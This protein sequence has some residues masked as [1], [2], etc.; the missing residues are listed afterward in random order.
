[1]ILLLLVTISLGLSS[2]IIYL[3][4]GELHVFGKSES[5][6]L[7]GI[8]ALFI[9]A[10][11]VSYYSSSTIFSEFCYWGNVVCGCFFFLSGMGLMKSRLLK[12]ESYFVGFLSKHL[13]KLFTT[14][15]LVA[16][17]WSL[18]LHFIVGQS[19]SSYLSSIKFGYT[20]IP[21]TW[22]VYV[23]SLLYLF[24]YV[25]FG[26]LK[27][28][29]Y[30]YPLLL[31]LLLIILYV[32]MTEHVKLGSFWY[33]SV[34][35]FWMGV[36]FSVLEYKN[37]RIIEKGFAVKY[38]LICTMTIVILLVALY[39]L[40]ARPI[41]YAPFLC[42]LFPVFLYLTLCVIRISKVA[43]IG[44][45]GRISY[46][47]YVVHGIFVYYLHSFFQGFTLFAVVTVGSVL[48]SFYLNKLSVR[49]NR[50]L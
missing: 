44:F 26:W 25:T 40:Y 27:S 14:V 39:S 8:L 9:V 11:H 3:R 49:L 5:Q 41:V 30:L 34:F 32:Y 48:T 18:F 23:L 43:V 17:L 24:Y 33:S 31:L 35:A 4:S 38:I 19:V 6:S 13:W 42:T 2:M 20:F 16:I 36:F 28:K 50:L 21:N 46:E 47:L 45:V 10:H 37:K 7:K 29:R 12:G 22:F 1:M 15:F